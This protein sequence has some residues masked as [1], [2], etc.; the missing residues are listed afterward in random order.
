MEEFIE[1]KIEEINR[2]IGPIS[3]NKGTDN[4]NTIKR[5]L[6]ETHNKGGCG[7]NKVITKVNS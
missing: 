4:Y 3:F 5:I 6:T 1:N 7:K 2:C